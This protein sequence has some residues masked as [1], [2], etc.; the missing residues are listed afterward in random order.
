MN[1]CKGFLCKRITLPAYSYFIQI[2]SGINPMSEQKLKSSELK[3]ND[4]KPKKHVS[5]SSLFGNCSQ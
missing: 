1:E 5:K 4:S 2:N 3:L